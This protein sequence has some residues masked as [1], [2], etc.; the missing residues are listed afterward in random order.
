[1]PDYRPTYHVDIPMK[2][3]LFQN[4]EKIGRLARTLR[5]LAFLVTV[6]VCPLNLLRA[7]TQPQVTMEGY[8]R[9]RDRANGWMQETEEEK[10]KLS[11]T[12]LQSRISELETC[13]G[14]YLQHEEIPIPPDPNIVM[15]AETRME[16]YVK[17]SDLTTI[18]VLETNY[19]TRETLLLTMQLN[20]EMK[21]ELEM[22]DF[23]NKHHL[24]KV[25]AHQSSTPISTNERPK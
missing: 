21:K 25:F 19:L 1:M 6:L 23:I 17:R 2:T 15:S 10:L 4:Q 22:I 8:V 7:Q 9:C 11:P 20:Q 13:Y 14:S 12:E 5:L 16:F 24:L 3:V 18:L